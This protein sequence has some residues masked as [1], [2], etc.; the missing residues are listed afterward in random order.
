MRFPVGQME[1]LA[2][3]AAE[4]RRTTVEPR[5][6]A[7]GAPTVQ[8]EVAFDRAPDEGPIVNSQVTAYDLEGLAQSEA[9]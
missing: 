7:A 2:V 4:P 6:L 8:A 1:R 5:L 3:R 9:I